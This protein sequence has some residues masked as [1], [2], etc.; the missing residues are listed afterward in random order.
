[1]DHAPDSSPGI[2][3]AATAGASPDTSAW[4]KYYKEASRRRRAAGYRDLRVVK[5]RRR[6]RERLS[7]VVAALLVGA[8]TAIFYL[9]LS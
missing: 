9:V 1:M 4:D 3:R 7:F 2:T 8:M 5:R 6:L